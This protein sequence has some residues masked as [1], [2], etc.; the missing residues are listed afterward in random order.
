MAWPRLGE[1]LSE[2]S[3]AASIINQEDAPQTCPHLGLM[4]AFPQLTTFSQV[5]LVHH[6]KLTK[7]TNVPGSQGRA[8]TAENVW[9]PGRFYRTFQKER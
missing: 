7:L 5:S 9:G 8:R 1:P 6:V 4:Q 3:P 2:V